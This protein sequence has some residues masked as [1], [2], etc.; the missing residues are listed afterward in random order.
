MAYANAVLNGGE[1]RVKN[2]IVFPV[3]CQRNGYK[4]FFFIL[5][6]YGYI[7]HAIQNLQIASRAA[8]SEKIKP[9]TRLIKGKFSKLNEKIAQQNK[10]PIFAAKTLAPALTINGLILRTLRIV[11]LMMLKKL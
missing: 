1:A 9:K 3:S 5:Y 10:N 8:H 2:G 4:P 11:L 6:I 7:L